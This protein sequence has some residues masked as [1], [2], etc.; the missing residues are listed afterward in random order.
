MYVCMDVEQFNTRIPT[1]LKKEIKKIALR[2]DTTLEEI[3]VKQLQDYVKV[4]GEGNPVYSLN[5]WVENEKFK[6]V[7]AL[8]SKTDV[9]YQYLNNCNDAEKMEIYDQC[10]GMT[11]MMQQRKLI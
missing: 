3:V 11:R 5:K 6:A 8:F 2:E 7:P 9:W 10:S 1:Q 4:H